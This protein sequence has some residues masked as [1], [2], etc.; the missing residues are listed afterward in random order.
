M[1]YIISSY[2]PA[3]GRSSDQPCPSRDKGDGH[4]VRRLVGL[5]KEL[6]PRPPR[7][8]MFKVHCLDLWKTS[9]C[10]DM[11]LHEEMRGMKMRK[12]Q[13][14]RCS[15]EFGCM[16]VVPIGYW[17]CTIP[18]SAFTC[19]RPVARRTDHTSPILFVLPRFQVFVMVDRMSVQCQFHLVFAFSSVL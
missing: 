2:L 6:R 16:P 5:G 7:Q 4:Y 3:A 15:L 1:D 8:K 9:V 11:L 12:R 17:L 14:K 13:T 19:D 10:L 18:S